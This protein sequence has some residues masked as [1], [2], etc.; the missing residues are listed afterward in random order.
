MYP[1]TYFESKVKALVMPTLVVILLLGY[2]FYKEIGKP[3]SILTPYFFAEIIIVL[4]IIACFLYF[5]PT[6]TLEIYQDHF[7]YKKGK[8]ILSA[9][10]PEVDRITFQIARGRRGGG[11]TPHAFF[12]VT[13]SDRTKL[14]D[15]SIMKLKDG[16][17]NSKEFVNELKTL[18]GKELTIGDYSTNNFGYY[19]PN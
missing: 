3:E 9:K 8:K 2:G 5:Y 14:I 19:T 4:I 6:A 11:G 17:F 1:K 18:S 16:K 15:T 13:S 7:V 10:W 12:I